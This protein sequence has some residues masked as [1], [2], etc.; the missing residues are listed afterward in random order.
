MRASSSRNA[1]GELRMNSSAS[2]GRTYSGSV[3]AHTPRSR[4]VIFSDWL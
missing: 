2:S 4:L 1:V 3:A